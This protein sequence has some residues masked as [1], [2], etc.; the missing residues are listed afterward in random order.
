[1]AFSQKDLDNIDEAIATGARSVQINGKSV[2]FDN[3]AG[4]LRR[5][6]LIAAELGQSKPGNKRRLSVFSKGL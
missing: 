1:M 4:L 3:I 5:R 6:R 2:D